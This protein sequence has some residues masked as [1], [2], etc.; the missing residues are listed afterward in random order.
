V[1]IGAAEL[2]QI[3][4]SGP[5]R[6]TGLTLLGNGAFEFSF[7]NATGASFTVFASTNVSLPFAQ[8]SNLGHAT[9]APA[10]SGQF[11]F[12]DPQATNNKARFYRVRSP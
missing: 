2:Q 12:T 8:W 3:F 9:E 4:P 6:L 1:G 5:P 7:T 11:Q 10:G